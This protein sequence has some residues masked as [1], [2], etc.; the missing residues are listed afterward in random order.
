M[1]QNTKSVGDLAELK[2][3][4][5]LIEQGYV[6]SAPYGDNAPYDLIVDING[7]LKKVQVKARTVKNDV[8][9]VELKSSMRNY[10]RQYSKQDWDIIAIYNIDNGTIAYL[11]WNAIGDIKTT[12]TLRTVR[13]KNNQKSMMFEE[14]R[15]IPR[16]AER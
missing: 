6:V 11:D 16:C 10:T 7:V 2:I 1:R 15:F 4:S 14:Y 5:D 9:T 13:P 8:V 3:A 12:L